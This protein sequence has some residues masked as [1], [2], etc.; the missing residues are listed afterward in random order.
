MPSLL[1]CGGG[2]HRCDEWGSKAS[3]VGLSKI[4]R[5]V[6]SWEY[7]CMVLVQKR[8]ALHAIKAR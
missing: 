7:A 6:A 5:E 3:P 1:R 2:F 8:V 4:L